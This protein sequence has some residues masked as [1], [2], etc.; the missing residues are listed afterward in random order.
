MRN[1]LDKKIPTLVGLL[2]IILGIGGTTFL[3]RSGTLFEIM[4]TPQQD[5]KGVLITNISDSSFTVSYLTDDQVIGTLNWGEKGDL[6]NVALDDR[7]QL[8]QKVNKHKVHSI[9][10][11]GLEPKTIYYFQITSGDKNY[12][13]NDS[14]YEVRTGS[15]I[16]K[17]PSQQ[18][19]LTG[20][21]IGP[22]G[23][24]PLE[25]LV[26]VSLSN[27]QKLST[28]LKNDGTYTVPLNTLRNKSL[29]DYLE[30]FE[31]S[32]INIE[33]I[34]E[35]LFSSVSISASEISPVPL[36][37]LSNSYDFST[38]QQKTEEESPP[39]AAF[40]TLGKLRTQSK[41][42]EAPKPTP[43]SR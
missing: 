19:P 24:I 8:S 32:I 30:L 33:V 22:N 3:V 28:Y 29:S 36:I 9:T 17:D 43:S 37:T 25:G 7:D 6:G 1:L 27:S 12:K 4:A 41:P 34:S 10:V 15:T 18:N 39:A 26:I 13:D 11:R 20:K 38:S 14:F 35:D 23:N 21:V 5:P 2:L 40:P 16:Q 31:N 42:S